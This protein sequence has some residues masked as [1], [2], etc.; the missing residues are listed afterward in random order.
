MDVLGFMIKEL[1]GTPKAPGEHCYYSVPAAPVDNLSRD[2]IYHKRVFEKIV[3]QCGFTA[4][5]SNEAMAIIYAE[6]AKDNF[7]ALS[8]SFG[9]GMTNIALGYSAVETMSFSVERGGDWID[10]DE[11]GFSGIPQSIDQPQLIGFACFGFSTLI[12]ANE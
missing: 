5:P 1:L 12:R 3:S 2:V 9:S 10:G 4:T 7:S 11:F 8:F 6:A